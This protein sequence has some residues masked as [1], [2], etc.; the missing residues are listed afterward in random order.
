L[1]DLQ[2]NIAALDAQK[3][4]S[5]LGLN[6]FVCMTCGSPLI[7]NVIP[8]ALNGKKLDCRKIYLPEMQGGLNPDIGPCR[9]AWPFF[10][11]IPRI[12]V[13]DSSKA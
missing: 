8:G 10:I 5:D 13:V 6:N 12:Q 2:F 9:R 4:S 7:L 1:Y 3:L 11:P